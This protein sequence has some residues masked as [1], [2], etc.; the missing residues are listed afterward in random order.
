MIDINL[1]A[2]DRFESLLSCYEREQYFEEAGL[3]PR[4]V[5]MVNHDRA[6]DN[7]LRTIRIV[8]QRGLAD[9]MRVFKR[10]YAIERPELKH[11]SGD[12]RYQSVADCIVTER[13]KNRIEL[14]NNPEC[15]MARI[16]ALKEKTH[17]DVRMK[18]LE[19]LEEQ[20]K[21][22]MERSAKRVK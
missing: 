16:E 11:I 21:K 6:Y 4:T 22:E 19:E 1:L 13:A 14:L 8:E 15:F 2:V 5:T 20:F 7:M 9:R 3:P 17:E 12:R 10:G 18:K